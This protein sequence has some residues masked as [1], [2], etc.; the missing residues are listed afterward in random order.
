MLPEVERLNLFARALRPAALAVVCAAG[1]AAAQAQIVP[2]QQPPVRRGPLPP[3][4]RSPLPPIGGTPQPG[5]PTRDRNAPT[6]K[7]PDAAEVTPTRATSRY[8]AERDATYVNVPVTLLAHKSVKDPKGALRF[9]G[10]EVVL[11]FQFA[12]RGRQTYDLASAFL[13]LESTAAPTEPD[14][15]SGPRTLR[16]NADPYEY[17]Y[18]RLD[19]RTE[20]VSPVGAPGQQ[21]RKEIAAFK[22]PAEDLPQLTGAGRLLVKFGSESFTVMSGQLSELRR[23]LAVGADK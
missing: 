9:E 8:D 3:T 15:L 10:R 22:L 6:M 1:A 13:I 11:N 7:K 23:T 12:Y 4:G 2:Q 21:L 14:R 5:D 18:E 20:L 19:Y 16:I 17:D